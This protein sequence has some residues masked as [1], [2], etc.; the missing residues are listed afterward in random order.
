LRGSWVSTETRKMCRKNARLRENSIPMAV[1][2]APRRRTVRLE[3]PPRQLELALRQ[4][5]AALPVKRR[6]DFQKLRNR[7]DSL[8]RRLTAA[9]VV[10]LVGCH[11]AT[12]FRWRRQGKFPEKH[13]FGGWRQSDIERWLRLQR[14]SISSRA[15]DQSPIAARCPEI[16]TFRGKTAHSEHEGHVNG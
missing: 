7:I 5:D 13:P 9:E 16:T 2:T 12:L 3:P 10:R 11:R 6:S 4:P 14:T 1:T 8:D 15:P